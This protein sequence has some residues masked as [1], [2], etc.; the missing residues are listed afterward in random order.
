MK[1]EELLLLIGGFGY[2]VWRSGMYQ[3]PE[4]IRNQVVNLAASQIGVRED[5]GPDKD[6]AGRIMTYMVSCGWN[7]DWGPAGWCMG[8]SGWCWNVALQNAGYTYRTGNGRFWDTCTC[9]VAEDAAKRWGIYKTTD[10]QPGDLFFQDLT[11]AGKS[12]HVGIVASVYGDTITTIQG[13]YSNSVAQVTERP[14]KITG[15]ADISK[16]IGANRA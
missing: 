15:Y 16:A 14:S 12:T 10:P 1:P 6:R 2:L 9:Y 13:N 7:Q 5:A 8:F 3:D 4:T 11:G